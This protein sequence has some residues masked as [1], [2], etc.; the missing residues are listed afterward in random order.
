VLQ[1]SGGV[2]GPC[3]DAASAS[4]VHGTLIVYQPGHHRSRTYASVKSVGDR[5]V[6]SVHKSGNVDR[7]PPRMVRGWVQGLCVV[8]CPSGSLVRLRAVGGARRCGVVSLP[9]VV[10]STGTILE[11]WG[12]ISGLLVSHAVANVLDSSCYAC[13]HLTCST[14]S[15]YCPIQWSSRKQASEADWYVFRLPFKDRY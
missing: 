6:S 3:G 15:S 9:R 10:G 8:G 11:V 14:R 12:R 7:T 5:M 1:S 13:A 2:Q 4:L